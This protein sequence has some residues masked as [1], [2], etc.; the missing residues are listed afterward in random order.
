MIKICKICD[1]K[2]PESFEICIDCATET[3]KNWPIGWKPPTP[4]IPTLNEIKKQFQFL[5]FNNNNEKFWMVKDLDTDEIKVGMEVGRHIHS[6]CID[7]TE[8]VVLMFMDEHGK[9]TFNDY[10]DLWLTELK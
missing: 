8:L 2:C 5:G 9:Q 3:I 1:N 10:A 4:K 6:C 7:S